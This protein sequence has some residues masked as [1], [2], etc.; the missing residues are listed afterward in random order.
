M[1]YNFINEVN[2]FLSYFDESEFIHYIYD[3]D[4]RCRYC[5]FKHPKVS[6]VFTKIFQNIPAVLE[7]YK[8]RDFKLTRMRNSISHWRE[9]HYMEAHKFASNIL[10]ASE[11]E[12]NEIAIDWLDNNQPIYNE[13]DIH[14]ECEDKILKLEDIFREE[15]IL[16]AKIHDEEFDRKYWISRRGKTWEHAPHKPFNIEELERLSV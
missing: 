2:E 5:W 10:G 8:E 14:K 7:T 9:A 11:E 6:K 1:K 12:K 3:M 4:Y 16:A 15:V 13:D